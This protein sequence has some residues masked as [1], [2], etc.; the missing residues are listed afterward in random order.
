MLRHALRRLLWLVPTLVAL[1]LASF[2]LLSFVPD[3]ADDRE[4]VNV[5][6]AEQVQALRRERFL[7]LPRFFNPRPT[8]IRTRVD[9]ILATLALDD[10]DAERAKAELLRL[11]G[12]TL[13]YLLPRLDAFEPES[14]TRIALALAPLGDRMGI[15]PDAVLLDPSRALV[16]WTRFW[17]ERE[18]DFQPTSARRAVRRFS[19]KPTVMREADIRVLDTYALGEIM[20]LLRELPSD[21]EIETKRRLVEIAAR[22]TGKDDTIP[23]DATPSEAR[24]CTER[25]LDFWLTHRADYIAFEGPARLAATIG[26]TQYARWFERMISLRLG[27]GNDGVPILDKLRER[28]PTTLAISGLAV[29][30]A[31]AIALPTGIVAAFRH[32]APGNELLLGLALASYAVP[33]ACLATLAASLVPE[34]GGIVLPAL[35]LAFA[36]VASPVRHLHARLVEILRLDFILAARARGLG[37]LRLLLTQALRNTLGSTITL[38]SLDFPM[39]LAGSFVVEKAFGLRGLGEETVRAVQ[40]RDVAWL[41]T[42]GFAAAFLSALMLLLSD[43]A[44]SIVDPRVRAGFLRRERLVP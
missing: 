12:A 43:V 2:A 11:G 38:L 17:A 34:G 4:L 25:W 16:F 42:L 23:Q 31:Y 6:G 32:R 37:P 36:F 9:E 39:A 27:F 13:P 15:A 18:A 3:P 26:E 20:R 21:G 35:V 8:D 40:T 10:R 30:L 19:L 28:A 22:I 1:T 41:M 44:N 5:L 29:F 14:R 7:D 33:S 24:A